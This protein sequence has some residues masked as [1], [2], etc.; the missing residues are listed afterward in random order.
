M[1]LNILEITGNSLDD[2][3]G[4]R[5]VIF[6]KGCPLSCVW[7]HNP[8]SQR[9]ASEISYD[10]QECLVCN[11]C[12]KACLY[13]ALSRDYPFFVNRNICTNCF[14]CVNI[15][16]T[17]ALSRVGNNRDI[18]D[19]IAEVEKDRPFFQTSNGGVT[20]SGGE[21]T[22]QMDALSE[23]LKGFREKA[24]H[25]LLETCGYFHWD[26]FQ[27]KVLPH[28]DMIYFDIKFLNSEAHQHY[29]GKDNTR[30]LNNFENLIHARGQTVVLPRIPLI[31]D[32]TATEKN[33]SD[34]AEFLNQLGVTQAHLMEYNPL[35]LDKNLKM[36]IVNPYDQNSRMSQ[37]M[38]AEEIKKYNKILGKAFRGNTPDL[39]GIVKKQSHA[40]N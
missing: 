34:I 19:I 13:N 11:D 37:W 28:L 25:T 36:G 9:T 35:W 31:P 18:S 23:L 7:C 24:I 21:P 27:K 40:K 17:G 10:P 8:E 5:S 32:I 1:Q 3:P 22:L 4:I 16:P 39:H 30:I 26:S 15:C 14:E 38:T 33:L 29:C 6:F 20:I 2:G 12:I